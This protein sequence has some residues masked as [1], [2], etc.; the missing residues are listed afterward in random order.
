MSRHEDINENNGEVLNSLHQST[1]NLN[2]IT[3]PLYQLLPKYM[4]VVLDPIDIT[5]RDTSTIIKHE[6]EFHDFL[7]LMLSYKISSGE[8]IGKKEEQTLHDAIIILLSSTN[9]LLQLIN[10]DLKYSIMTYNKEEK[11][12][13]VEHVSIFGQPMKKYKLNAIVIRKN[14]RTFVII[15]DT[16]I[17]FIFQFCVIIVMF[18]DYIPDILNENTK[19]FKKGTESGFQ[20][21]VWTY[22]TLLKL[23]SELMLGYMGNSDI[24]K[25]FRELDKCQIRKNKAEIFHE[26]L[27]S[28]QLMV[29]L[30]KFIIA[31]EYG[32]IIDTKNF[33]QEA[34]RIDNGLFN[35]YSH[36]LHQEFEADRL[37]AKILIAS[38]I[39]KLLHPSKKPLPTYTPWTEIND[40]IT[41]SVLFIGMW[42][43]FE[44][45]NMARNFS[46][47]SYHHDDS[48]NEFKK[49]THPEMSARLEIV[50][51]AWKVV[52]DSS[53]GVA[54][55]ES[56]LYMS[57][58]NEMEDEVTRII[59]QRLGGDVKFWNMLRDA[60]NAGKFV[61]ITPELEELTLRIM[62]KRAAGLPLS[63][64]EEELLSESFEKAMKDFNKYR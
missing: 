28:Y 64:E 55:E 12:E 42:N 23:T 32:H 27:K 62:K 46:K 58:L 61:D 6:E 45:A 40:S 16:L 5:P 43:L 52:R 22:N 56:D 7:V 47:G 4:Q 54:F 29:G 35:L 31:H 24:N 38:A 49:K 44:E 11:F 25:I 34:S 33:T 51:D 26:I 15:D 3:L 17:K 57:L 13:F 53:K 60:R 8:S 48:A 2:D 30:I 18:R 59:V 19:D 36:N 9:S 14:P 1:L 10:K 63:S 20:S 21:E 41:G 37:A 39:A 50:K